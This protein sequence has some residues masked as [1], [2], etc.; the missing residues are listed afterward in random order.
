MRRALALGLLLGLASVAGA[1][2]GVPR[3]PIPAPF[4]TQTVIPMGTRAGGAYPF[5]P[6][7]VPTGVVGLTATIDVSEATDPLPQLDIIV[8]GSRDGGTTWASA[9]SFSNPPGNRTKI[10]GV[11]ITLI[12]A[13]FNGGPFWNDTANAQ[14]R[15]RGVASLGGSMRFAMTVTPQ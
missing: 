6:V 4:A 1:Q 8:E 12:G 5:N 2:I 10:Q 11:T 14:R 3:A 7:P 13:S 9:G 15:L